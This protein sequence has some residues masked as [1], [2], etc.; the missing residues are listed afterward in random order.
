MTAAENDALVRRFVKE[1]DAPATNAEAMG[2]YFTEDALY[3]NIPVAP[4]VGRAAIVAALAGINQMAQPAGWEIRWQLA[5]DSV[6][7]NERVDRF[8]RDGKAMELPVTGVFE[9]RDGKIA[10]WRDYF[11]MGMW[12]KQM[13]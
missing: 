3:H 5:N 9:I 12:Q 4:I 6:V 10:A 7:I 1:F 8:T 2:D 11:D 13:A